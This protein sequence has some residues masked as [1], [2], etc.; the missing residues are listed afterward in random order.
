MGLSQVSI[1]AMLDDLM[2]EIDLDALRYGQDFIKDLN[3]FFKERGFLSEKQEASL[4]KIYR[5]HMGKE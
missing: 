4:R 1:K 2:V 5:N 3:R